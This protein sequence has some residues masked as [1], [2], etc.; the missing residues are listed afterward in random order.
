MQA[1]CPNCLSTQ[2]D[3][4]ALNCRRCGQTRPA[5]GSW[6][7]DP[8]L[9]ALIDNGKYEIDGVLGVGGFGKVYRAH[10]TML[11]G[12]VF[13]IKVLNT[14]LVGDEEREQEF[15]QEV[16]IL[17]GLDHPNI[18]R[19]HDVGRLDTGA[20]FI[21]MEL[22]EGEAVHTQILPPTI[23]FS[24]GRAAK[25]GAQ[26][27]SALASA[28]QRRVLHRDL[29]PGNILLLK[30]DEV[31][32][33]DFGIAKVLESHQDHQLSR[34]VGTPDFMAPEQ[35]TPGM[36][37]DGRLDVYQLGA[38]LHFLLTGRPPYHQAQQGQTTHMALLEVAKEQEARQ[39]RDGPAPGELRAELLEDAPELNAFIAR[40]LATDPTRRPD[41][42]ESMETLDAL[43]ASYGDPVNLQAPHLLNTDA[44]APIGR[45]SSPAM[46]AH[47]GAARTRH[48]DSGVDVSDVIDAA[49][50][51]SSS[52][53]AHPQ[54]H[55]GAPGG[56]LAVG[57]QQQVSTSRTPPL[58]PSAPTPSSSTPLPSQP[59]PIA[60]T[61]HPL[62]RTE[63]QDLTIAVLPMRNHDPDNDH[64]AEGLTEDLTDAL[65]MFPSLKVRPRGVVVAAH[66]DTEDASAVGSALGV[67]YVVEGSLRRAGPRVQV[68]VRLISVEDGYQKW[69]Q[70]AVCSLDEFW[71]V[72]DDL[73]EA[74]AEALSMNR[75]ERRR[76]R[77][78]PPAE[79]VERY[80]RARQTLRKTWHGDLT[81]ANE[82]FTLAL[83]VAPED[84]MILSWAAVAYARQ[85][86]LTGRWE[87]SDLDV[88]RDMVQRALSAAPERCEPHYAQALLHHIQGHF[89]ATI[90]SLHKSLARSSSHAESYDLLGRVVLDRGPLEDA[91]KHLRTAIALEPALHNARFDLARAYALKREWEQARVMLVMATDQ[92]INRDLSELLRLR[93][94][95]WRRAEPDEDTVA[96]PSTP[97]TLIQRMTA[98][99]ARV[100][101]TK[102]LLPEDLQWLQKITREA[103]D[104]T[105]KNLFRQYHAEVAA[106]V[107][108]DEMCLHLIEVALVSGLNDIIWLHHCSL[109][110]PL[111]HDG[112]LIAL[113]GQNPTR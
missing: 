19:C 113:R 103:S 110:D 81:L 62:K 29:K 96:A 60:V 46:K 101:D 41:A 30:G 53:R 33:I 42:R 20:L 12:H 37:I 51:P 80:L 89:D 85:R 105:R 38:V 31:R 48:L 59:N 11:Q 17:L 78:P 66:R 86:W 9:G 109:L 72:G 56:S 25:V 76:P 84:P 27:A 87:A 35:L 26:V 3:E 69:A 91:I 2:P 43:A 58:T 99:M 28:H 57:L 102:V 40:M 107:G 82:H 95:L 1:F 108:D 61:P 106:Y 24:P 16:H 36:P 45:S 77:T 74:L 104:M 14:S 47:R 100:R 112:R 63:Q 18:V 13:A 6:P 54:P 70:R 4:A 73:A 15:L 10:H 50:A 44:A 68:R 111:R 88:A 92:T 93:F 55:G 39:E 34:V 67:A 22:V 8:L 79:A 23:V 49:R 64:L 5:G 90:S 21:R 98:L 83:S 7:Q 65:S 52:Q 32:V 75:V 97:R 94:A 71:T